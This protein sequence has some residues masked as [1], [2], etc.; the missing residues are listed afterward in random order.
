MIDFQIKINARKEEFKSITFKAFDFKRIMILN[1]DSQDPDKKLFN[2]FNFKD[3]HY[4]TSEESSWNLKCFD[5]NPVS[6]LNL[7]ISRKTL[8]ALAIC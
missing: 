1:N 4:C 7:N 6:M 5:K 8:I 2:A 3:S